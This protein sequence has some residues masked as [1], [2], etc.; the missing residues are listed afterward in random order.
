LGKRFDGPYYVTNVEHVINESGY[1]T[2]FQVRRFFD[3][4]VT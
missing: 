4:K 3:G 2:K 1:R